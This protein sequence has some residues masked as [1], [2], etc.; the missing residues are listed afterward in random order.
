MKKYLLIIVF[1]PFLVLAQDQSKE[2][3]KPKDEKNKVFRVDKPVICGDIEIVIKTLSEELDQY[4]IIMGLGDDNKIVLMTN[5]DNS[6]WSIIEFNET[7]ACILNAG[8]KLHY[9]KRNTPAKF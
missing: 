5:K 1:L 7:T 8:K 2:G 9:R 3:S 6:S 4:P